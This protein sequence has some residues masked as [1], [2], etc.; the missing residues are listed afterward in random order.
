MAEIAPN[1]TAEIAEELEVE[2]HAPYLKVWAG[3]AILTGVEYV[4]ALVLKDHFVP[5]VLGLLLL[6]IVK[7]SMVGWYFMHLK[8]EKKWVYI[9][10]I[11]AGV[12]AVLLT[13]ALYPDMAMKPAVEENPG[14]E[15]TMVVPAPAG[16][17]PAGSCLAALPERSSSWLD[18]S[19]I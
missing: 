19:V 5:L 4:Y 13:L 10:I 7:A 15:H 18:R 11:P 17:G 12:M 3:L 14:E 6:A 1:L 2:S 9:L 8:F 16:F